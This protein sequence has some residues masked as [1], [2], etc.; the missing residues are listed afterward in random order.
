MII[1]PA[2]VP[3][4]DALVTLNDYVQTLHAAEYPE[5]FRLRPPAAEVADAF[6]KLLADPTALWLLAEAE[7]PCGYLYA[8][9]HEKPESW[10]RPAHRVC[11]INH[12]AVHPA[13]RR[14]GVARQ[15][16]AAVAAEAERRGFA[17][18]ELDVWSFNQPARAAFQRL[19]FHVFNER[20][21]RTHRIARVPELPNRRPS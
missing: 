5:L 11:N 2:G 17:R 8:Q 19:G 6:R 4:L 14:R 7:T 10:S 3:D 18:V 15:L 9:F 13:A 21:A 1:R 20:M 12:L 16:I